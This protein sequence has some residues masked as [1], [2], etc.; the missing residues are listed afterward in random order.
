MIVS[1]GFSE[2]PD[3]SPD[4]RWIAFDHV[5]PGDHARLFVV[6]ADG[7]DRRQVTFHAGD[8]GFPSW[9]P[10]GRRLVFDGSWPDKSAAG[11][12]YGLGIVDLQTG[13]V[14]RITHG[15]DGAPAWSPD[16]RLI[17]FSR[18]RPNGI[19]LFTVHPDGTDVHQLTSYK[20]LAMN[21]D[22]SPDGSRIVFNDNEDLPSGTVTQDVMVIG[23]HGHD[24]RNVTK[25]NP[26]RRASFMP[27]WSPDG[28]KIVF[29]DAHVIQ[30]HGL[31][32]FV[33]KPNGQG[34]HGL[35]FRRN[36]ALFSPDWGTRPTD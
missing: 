6:R 30:F 14:H 8:Q 5:V 1:G 2:Q 12:H 19:A 29:I 36:L 31:E 26:A 7:S 25:N 35:G 22:W 10:S 15:Q 23:R 16:G 13:S 18:H 20:L 21:A 11:I 17:V 3:W 9:D 4:G 34:E 32:L 28:R 27:T 24:L 33:I